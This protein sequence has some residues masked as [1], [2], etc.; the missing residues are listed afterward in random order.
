M[1]VKEKEKRRK[2]TKHL[3]QRFTIKTLK[4]MKEKGRVKVVFTG[5]GNTDFEWWFSGFQNDAML[6][7]QILITPISG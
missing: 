2:I 7:L 6:F 3:I 5:K 1:I 4:K